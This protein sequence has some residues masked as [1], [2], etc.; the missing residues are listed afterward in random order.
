MDEVDYQCQGQIATILLNRPA[1]KN[2]LTRAMWVELRALIA[3]AQ[4][5][6][7]RVL[8][9]RTEGDCFCAGADI[10]ELKTHIADVDWL[11][12]NH[13]DVQAATQALRS[14]PIP[15][16]A[17][18][19]GACVGGGLGLAAA[20]DFRYASSHATF[21]LTPAKLGLNYSLADT[22][23]LVSLI[24]QARAREL[25]FCAQS[26]SAEQALAFGFLHCSDATELLENAVAERSDALL[27]CSPQAIRALKQT[28]LAIEE[29]QLQEDDHSRARFE[30][31]FTSADFAEGAQ[32]FLQKRA[33][34]FGLARLD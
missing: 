25:L 27:R 10:A 33:P 17:V 19:D 30:A 7:A 2:A 31:A 6:Q 5:D 22:R 24:G 18:I 11:Q 12:A 16:I 20:C 9:L 29:G 28:L 21:A 23:R 34:H 1:K 4:F 32:A 14:C 3:R 8:M 26:W 13:H 15:S